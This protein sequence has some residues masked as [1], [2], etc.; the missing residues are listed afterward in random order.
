M[1]NERLRLSRVTTQDLVDVEGVFDDLQK[2]STYVDG[3]CRREGA[4]FEF[5][6]ARPPSA[7]I[8]DKHSFVAHQDGYPVGLL[9][10]IDGY[11]L[12]GT[13]FIGLLAVRENLH[14]AGLGRDLYTQAETFIRDDL[15][16]RVIRLAV[17]EAN[18]VGG[19]WKRM[20]FVPTGEWKPYEVQT[21]TSRLIL[22]EK[23]ICSPTK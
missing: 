12:L 18:P 20:G 1:L 6:T 2:Y 11:P 8:E 19:F 22:M 5:A 9:D 15:E 7:S 4:A 23:L 17:V 14:G 21:V 3:G 16:A 10:I 13:A